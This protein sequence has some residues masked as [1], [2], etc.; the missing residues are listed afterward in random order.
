MS[1]P[2]NTKPLIPEAVLDAYFQKEELQVAPLG[3]GNINDTFLV[4][5]PNRKVV[6]QRINAAVFSKPV[7]VAANFQVV[8][9]HIQQKVE[10]A[11]FDYQC[12]DVIPT[13]AGTGWYID[14]HGECWRAQSYINHIAPSG[15]CLDS[16]GAYQLGL[17]LARFHLL[18]EELDLA[19]LS[20]PIPGFHR[21]LHYLI[22][23]DAALSESRV[24]ESPR[25][26]QCLKYA[27]QF[28][29]RAGVLEQARASGDLV[30]RV[31]HGDPKLDNV[32]WNPGGRATGLF[33]LDTVG[34]GLRL[35]DLGDCLRS[36]CNLVGEDAA[37]QDVIFATVLFRAVLE[38]YFRAGHKFLGENE[39]ALIVDSVLTITVELAV[40][41]LTDYLRGNVYFKISH[42]GQNL[43]RAL[44]Q[45]QLAE[46]IASQEK[47][48]RRIVG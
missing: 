46:S 6:L 39:K 42:E 40:R 41:F 15:G 25:L 31:M 27:E 45:F 34:P 48:L 18:T 16:E 13:C 8:S 23:F 24:A 5:T 10:K 37:T 47:E 19:S 26:A 12:A 30:L 17:V 32:I 9:E 38:G 14:E 21:T 20:E 1:I 44:V 3:K 33:D 22:Q 28:R 7:A 29:G 4:S 11:S 36:S 35:Y 43:D 2:N